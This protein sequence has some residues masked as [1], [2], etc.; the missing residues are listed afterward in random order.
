MANVYLN[1]TEGSTAVLKCP[2]NPVYTWSDA[3]TNDIYTLNDGINQELNISMKMYLDDN[4]NLLINDFGKDDVRTYRC[5]TDDK[6]IPVWYDFNIRLIF[7]PIFYKNYRNIKLSSVVGNVTNIS[8]DVNS[9]PAPT[10]SWGTGN[11]GTLGNWKISTW[12]NT[13]SIHRLTSSVFLT[14]RDQ[15]GLYRAVIRNSEGSI[16]ICIRFVEENMVDVQPKHVVCY[17]TQTVKLRCNIKNVEGPFPTFIWNH[18]LN[19]VHIR[20][21]SGEDHNNISVLSITYCNYQDVGDYSCTVAC[22]GRNMTSTAYVIV[23]GAPVIIKQDVITDSSNVTLSVTYI[24]EPPLMYIIWYINDENVNESNASNHSDIFIQNIK[25]NVRVNY[26]KTLITRN[27][28]QS[29]LSF[30]RAVVSHMDTISCHLKNFIGSREPLF[31]ANM[32][33]ISINNKENL[34]SNIIYVKPT[35][36]ESIRDDITVCSDLNGLDNEQAGVSMNKSILTYMA[37][38]CAGVLTTIII[39]AAIV[40]KYVKQ[41][42]SVDLTPSNRASANRQIESPVEDD[43]SQSLNPSQYAEIDDVSYHSITWRDSSLDNEQEYIEMNAVVNNDSTYLSTQ[44][45]EEIRDSSRELRVYDCTSTNETGVN[46][47]SG[48][49]ITV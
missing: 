33:T 41:K 47:G 3:L 9:Y 19:G 40:R 14:A 30:S 4:R 5:S 27:V 48:L 29:K 16:D 35:E 25:V 24:S 46:T 22:N 10:V 28:H 39:V 2:T 8:L 6:G 42:L 43:T 11:G 49:N 26:H 12:S 38:L 15:F 21:L 20:R 37:V 7:K 36:L 13:T 32:L 31:E 34:I 45:Y 17:T 44:Y 23:Q 1:V 18:Y